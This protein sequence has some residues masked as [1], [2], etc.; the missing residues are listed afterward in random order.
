[1]PD[2]Q[3]LTRDELLNLA[4]QRDQLTD[5]ARFELDS[6]IGKRKIA[7]IEISGYARETLAQRDAAE[8]RRKRSRTYYEGRNNRFIGK[9]NPKLDARLRVEE[10]DTTLWLVI[11]ISVFPLAS[12]RIRRRHRRWWNPFPSAR[13]H[14]LETKPRDWEQILWTWVKTAAILLGLGLTLFAARGIRP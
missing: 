6:E 4:Q 3:Y 10:F 9:T 5:E 2:Y 8:R 14:V 12:Y 13:L 11:L 1:M 7:A